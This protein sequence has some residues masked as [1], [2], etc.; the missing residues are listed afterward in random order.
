MSKF[1]RVMKALSEIKNGTFFRIQYLSDVPVAK[2]V[3]KEYGYDPDLLRIRKVT[4]V[5]ARTGVKYSNIKAV[6]E[7]LENRNGKET[8]KRENN[9]Y[10]VERNRVKYNTATGKYYLTL[11]TVNQ[12]GNINTMYEVYY[13]GQYVHYITPEEFL[14]RHFDKIIQSSY[15]S[16]KKTSYYCVSFDHIIDINEKM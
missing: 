4:T 5:T 1:E 12:H 8:P 10:W 7:E 13:D 2:K 11:A 6:A 3:V 14:L 9:F 16:K 15:F